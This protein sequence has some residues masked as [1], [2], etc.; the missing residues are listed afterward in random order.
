[1]LHVGPPQGNYAV[2]QRPKAINFPI[3]DIE[4]FDRLEELLLYRDQFLVR[5]SQGKQF[6]T[7]LNRLPF[8]EVDLRNHAR[9]GCGDM[10]LRLSRALDD[11]GGNRLRSFERSKFDCRR[12]EANVL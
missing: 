7:R 4:T 1:M 8:N 12:L 3:D 9:K 6:F 2:A 5:Q 10:M 11:D